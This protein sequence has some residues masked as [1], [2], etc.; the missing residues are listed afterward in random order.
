MDA[1]SERHVNDTVKISGD[2]RGY[3]HVQKEH[4]YGVDDLS[5]FRET[6]LALLNS[7]ML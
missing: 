6:R 4:Y 3:L 2:R 7:L 5:L 1:G